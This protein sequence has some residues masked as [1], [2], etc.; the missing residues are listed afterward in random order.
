[1]QCGAT[2]TRFDVGQA[3]RYQACRLATLLVSS[4]YL[5]HPAASATGIPYCAQHHDAIQVIPPKEMFA[6]TPW[7]YLPGFEERMETRRRAFLMWRSLPMMRRY[8]EANR[9]AKSGVSTGYREPNLLQ[10]TVSGAFAKPQTQ[11]PSAE[12]PSTNPTKPRA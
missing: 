2:P 11:G 12:F 7:K 8:L 4:V 10:K 9:R 3:V 6:W 1:V 5:P